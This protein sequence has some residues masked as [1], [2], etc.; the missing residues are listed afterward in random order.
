MFIKVES[1][2][3]YIQYIYTG[4]LKYGVYIQ[5]HI[6]QQKGRWPATDPGNSSGG[7]R[8]RSVH[9][10]LRAVLAL[11]MPSWVQVRGALC[12]T[13]APAALLPTFSVLCHVSSYSE[14]T[15]ARPHMCTHTSK[16]TYHCTHLLTQAHPQ[17]PWENAQSWEGGSRGWVESRKQPG[18]AA[19]GGIWVMGDQNPSSVTGRLDTAGLGT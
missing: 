5:W 3:T 8:M 11:H 19:R 14:H 1:G 13:A 7:W 2:Y 12:L 15:R 16:H 9:S 6:V 17:P 4:T 10:A 18:E